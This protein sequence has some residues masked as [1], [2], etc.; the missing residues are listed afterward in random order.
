MQET[1]DKYMKYMKIQNEI[2]ELHSGSFVSG[3]L[4]NI[5]GKLPLMANGGF[6]RNGQ[7]VVA[8]AGPELLEIV[9]GGARVTP[10]SENSRNIATNQGRKIFYSNYT[11]NATI[12]DGYDVSRLAEELETERRRLERGMGK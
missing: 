8:E 10:L 9:N 12:S 2:S 3:H 5:L 6:L 11:I 1:V 4:S 7:A